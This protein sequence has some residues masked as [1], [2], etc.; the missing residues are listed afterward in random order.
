LLLPAAAFSFMVAFNFRLAIHVADF[1]SLPTRPIFKSYVASN[2]RNE[3][4]VF[5]G[6][7]S[8]HQKSRGIHVV[9]QCSVVK[10]PKRSR[11][12]TPFNFK[13]WHSSHLSH[14]PTQAL[15][16]N[17]SSPHL[18]RR[19]F[20]PSPMWHS[21]VTSKIKSRLHSNIHAAIN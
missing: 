20:Y 9:A 16:D 1:Y 11:L 7:I 17:S 10:A 3:G 21:L 19:L 14:P 18:Y 15:C 6:K 12:A 4:G 13:W 5:G 2:F 8:P